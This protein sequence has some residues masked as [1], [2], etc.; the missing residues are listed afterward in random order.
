MRIVGVLP[1]QSG[2]VAALRFGCGVNRSRLAGEHESDLQLAG[3][4]PGERQASGLETDD[5]RDAFTSERS[6][7]GPADLGDDLRVPQHQR[8]VGVAFVPAERPQHQAGD[9]ADRNPPLDMLPCSAQDAG[10]FPADRFSRS[11]TAQV[12][13]AWSGAVTR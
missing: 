12:E 5:G 9:A 7:E 10:R 13:V 8:E 1:R 6:S 4:Q 2:V 11:I 3:N